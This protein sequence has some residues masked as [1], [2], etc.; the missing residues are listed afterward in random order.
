MY[1][2]LLME[3]AYYRSFSTYLSE[4]FDQRVYRVSLDAG[5]SC[6]NR[7][8]YAVIRDPAVRKGAVGTG[9]CAYCSAEGSWNGSKK[10]LSLE[11]QVKT[12]K[13]MIG[14][15][16]NASKF[17]A[18]FQ[19]YSN[20]YAPVDTLREIYDSVVLDDEDFVGLIIG[21][22]PD[23]IDYEKLELISSYKERGLEVWLEYGLQSSN[24][25]TLEIIGRGHTAEDFARAVYMTKDFGISVC[26]HVIIGLPGE[27]SSDILNTARFLSGLPVEGVKLH[28][29][30]IVKGTRMA[31]EYYRGNVMP[32]ALDEYARLAVGFLERISPDVVVQRLVAQTSSRW[33]LG[34]EWSLNK[35][36]AVNAI[37]EEFKRRNSFQGKLFRK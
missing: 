26:A 12:G 28:N 30:N 3:T 32:L 29:L 1:F 22:R 24:D 7:N 18:Y 34:P 35:P 6:P 14:R 5:F 31:D 8:R 4:K 10:K 11:D 13:V 15:R 2:S 37:I 16:Y 9:G 21:T 36:M 17:L 20:T 33:L 25:R 27:S 19:A 23:C